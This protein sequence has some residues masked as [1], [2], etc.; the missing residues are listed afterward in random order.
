MNEVDKKRLEKVESD[1]DEAKQKLDRLR[2]R[3]SKPPVKEMQE[4]EQKLDEAR[5]KYRVIRDEVRNG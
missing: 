2:N 1:Y 4:A 5:R 3:K